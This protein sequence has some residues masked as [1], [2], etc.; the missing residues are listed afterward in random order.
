MNDYFQAQVFS[1]STR[2]R[3]CIFTLVAFVSS[4]ETHYSCKLELQIPCSKGNLLADDEGFSR[5]QCK[6]LYL[7]EFAPT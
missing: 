7:V 6:S 2:M 5:K 1:Q 3:R 4:V